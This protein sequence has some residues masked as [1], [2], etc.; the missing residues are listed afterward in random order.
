M[1]RSYARSK[2]VP[3]ADDIVQD[4]FT[5]M[6]RYL[7]S[8][9]GDESGLRSLL[10]TVAFRR[11]ADHHRRSYR[12][13]ETL[14]AEYQPMADPTQ[15]VEDKVTTRH[16][17]DRALKAF[18]I[19]T[20]RERQVLELRLIQDATPAEVAKALGLANTNVRVIQAR[21][22]AKVRNHLIT[23]Q[24]GREMLGVGL[25]FATARRFFSD[26]RN[27]PEISQWAA[28]VRQ[29]HGGEM[30]IVHRLHG[31][32]HLMTMAEASQ[33]IQSLLPSL[34][35]HG[36]AVIAAIISLV[37]ISTTTVVAP[38]TVEAPA[39][40]VQVSQIV[41]AAPAD[42]TAIGT[43]DPF[44]ATDPSA[45]EAE[46][47]LPGLVTGGGDGVTD[48]GVL[49]PVVDQTVDLLTG[50]LTGLTA[51]LV[52]PLVEGLIEGVV[53][54]LVDD[55]IEPLVEDTVEVVEEVV[56]EVEEVVEEVVDAVKSLFKG[57]LLP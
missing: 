12:S 45:D 29:D 25:V 17:A 48:S 6:V 47:N 1:I 57:L 42:V 23:Q 2:G 15:T 34:V 33:P 30:E 51:G 39:P 3:H 38:H 18:D 14:V 40:V 11:I 10:F 41:G 21:A 53:D 19:L 16:S 26:W 27:D 5:A 37:A 13:Q 7:S 50:T 43:A 8:F 28:E 52:D 24:G 46:P 56:E 44:D 31:G 49:A 4:V 20:M 36:A 55:V 32:N 9:Q 54:P 35:Q 22:L